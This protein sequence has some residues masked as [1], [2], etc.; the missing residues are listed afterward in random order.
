MMLQVILAIS[1]VLFCFG[2]LATL[3]RSNAI[4]VLIGIELMLGAGNLNFIAFWKFSTH[5]ELLTGIMFAIFSIALAA[6]EAAV[7]LAIVIQVHRRLRSV[8]VN[9]A[10]QLKG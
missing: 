6:A 7:G 1:A 10:T 9:R 8:N 2:L 3:T 4:M 5:P